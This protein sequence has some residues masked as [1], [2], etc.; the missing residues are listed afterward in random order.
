MLRRD[1]FAHPL[2]GEKEKTEAVILCLDIGEN[3]A[4]GITQ[5]GRR[6]HLRPS[7]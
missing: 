5:A 7:Q 3:G 4:D 2:P 6:N 1:G